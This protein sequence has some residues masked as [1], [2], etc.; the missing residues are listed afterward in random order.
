GYLLEAVFET[1][2]GLLELRSK[3]YQADSSITMGIVGLPIRQ[4]SFAPPVIAIL[5]Y[6][7]IQL[8]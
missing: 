5:G 4:S 2:S 1:N 7:A 6:Y 3:R 8:V